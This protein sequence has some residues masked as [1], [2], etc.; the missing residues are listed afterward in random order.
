MRSHPLTLVLLL[1]G[2]GLLAAM[3]FAKIGVPFAELRDAYP[4]AG[5]RI[6]WLLSLISGVGAA[7]GTVAGTLAVRLGLRRIL[8]GGMVLGAMASLVQAVLPP[9]PVM[10]ALRLVEGASHLA[11]VVAAPT[12]IAQASP[13]AWRGSA[14]ALWS[15]FFGVAFALT[16]ALGLP[17]VQ[18]LG[19][20]ALFVAHGVLMLAAV[21]ALL[22]VHLPVV[23]P[24]T[25]YAP[26]SLWAQNR[27][28]YAS[29]AIAAPGYGWLF[30]TLTFV[31][32]LAL[33]PDRAP[34]EARAATAAAMSLGSIAVSL[35]L[36][37]LLLRRFTAVT[38]LVIG[39]GLG[40]AVLLAAPVLPVQVTAIAV[41]AALGLVQGASFA[42]VPE[43]NPTPQGQA[44]AYGVM[45]QMGNLGNLLGTPIFLAILG[46]GS[47]PALYAT[48]AAL[49]A[50]AIAAHRVLAKR[51]HVASLC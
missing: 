22:A 35:L 45:A 50:G 27:Q 36:V 34:P 13:P 18:A 30:Y 47:E 2:V 51:R 17:L 37:P 46:W 10:L 44:M 19:L 11:I 9:L 1:W 26:L 31:A 33:L 4:D 14:M 3:Q 16:A 28:A 6:G 5:A 32:F 8:L 20:P 49:Y 25:A 38:V 42:S 12:L 48:G 43:L 41:F 29:P 15:T 7:L 39:F 23:A 24:V 40:L 21:A